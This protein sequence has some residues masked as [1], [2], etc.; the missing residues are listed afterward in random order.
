MTLTSK[1]RVFVEEY[2]RCWNA[3]E[4]AR[5][6][7]YKHP[8]KLGPRLVKVGIIA[9]EIKRRIAEKAMATDEIL[10]RLADQARTDMGPF[11]IES[12]DNLTLDWEKLKE[13]GLTH[14]V[15]SLTPTR[16]GTK[17]ELH[18]AQAAL[19]HLARSHG[20]FKDRMDITSGGE[21]IVQKVKGFDD[22]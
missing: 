4:A 5:R 16:Y 11:V 8:N 18:D 12:D 7:G 9:E 1:R 10:L 13:A 15:K 17:I 20:M 3:T 2:L 6:V 21:P 22:V 14:L 19:M